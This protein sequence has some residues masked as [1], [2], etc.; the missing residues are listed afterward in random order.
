[1]PRIPDAAATPA[2]TFGLYDRG[3]LR[4]GMVAD[5]NVF[6]V[7]SQATFTDLVRRR[8]QIMFETIPVLGPQIA[9]KLLTEL[10]FSVEE[11][12]ALLADKVIRQ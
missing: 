5:I 7:F 11:V 12:D 8:L 3:L 4:P 2:S 6:D 9:P 10:G 1:M